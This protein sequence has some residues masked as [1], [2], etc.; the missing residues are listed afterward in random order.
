MSNSSNFDSENNHENLKNVIISKNGLYPCVKWFCNI[1]M[2]R[3]AA[4]F[5]IFATLRTL[6]E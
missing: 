2:V 3:T 4:R 5:K 6:K 1:E